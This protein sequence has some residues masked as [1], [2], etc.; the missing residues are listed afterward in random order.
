MVIG[1]ALATGLKVAKTAGKAVAKTAKTV[2]KVAGKTAEK[3]AKTA[4]KAIDKTAE[5]AGKV[6]TIQEGRD[7]AEETGKKIGRGGMRNSSK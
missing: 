2:G 5:T 7:R 6:G 1:I 3:T 4:G